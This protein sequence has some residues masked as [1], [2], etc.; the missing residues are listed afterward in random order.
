M[1][2]AA[3]AAAGDD[4]ADAAIAQVRYRPGRAVTVSYRARLRT[5]PALLVAHAGAGMPAGTAEL[6]DGA[7]RVGVWRFPN[8]PL[9]PGLRH[10]VDGELLPELFDRLGVAADVR[11]V[12]RRAYRPTRR[13][14]IEATT[15][16]GPCYLKVV[17]P[18]RAAALRERHNAVAAAIP[19]PGVIGADLD[20]GVLVLTAVPGAPLRD[21]LHA[22]AAPGLPPPGELVA[23]LD[24]LPALPHRAVGTLERAGEHAR[25]LAA[26]VPSLAGRLGE[27]A[28]RLE[29]AAEGKAD[30]VH[31]DFHPGQVMVRAGEVAGLVDVDAAGAGTRADDLATMLGYLAAAATDPAPP[32][33]AGAYVDLLRPT[34][35]SLVDPGELGRRGAAALLGFATMPF[36]AQQAGWPA[37]VERRVAQ[38]ERWL[39]GA[40][41]ARV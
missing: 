4:L 11:S 25:L 23:L 21:L 39:A 36:V 18:A 31:G 16:D 3:L 9:L 41:E 29:P 35:A 28:A 1:L 26:V 20:L 6:D 5:G 8:D 12:R 34:F 22:G 33:H 15:G 30:A 24:R 27:L 32:A 40:G 14:V 2:A 10:A 37:G 38:A 13:A 17:R 19:A 7:I